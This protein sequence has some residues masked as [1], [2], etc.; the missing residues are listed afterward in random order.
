MSV[1]TSVK[2]VAAGL[3][4]NEPWEAFLLKAVKPYVDIVMQAGIAERFYF[5][6]S[7]ERGPHIRL[8]F[9]GKAHIIENMLKP[10]MEEHFSYFFE[11]RGS[12]RVNPVYPDNFPDHL[13][14]HPNNS[15]HYLPHSPE[16]RRYGGPVAYSV[17]EKNFEASSRIVLQSLYEKGLRWTYDDALSTA[18]K[19]HICFAFAIG[20]DVEESALFFGQLYENWARGVFDDRSEGAAHKGKP[21]TERIL[22]FDRIYDMQKAS[23]IAFNHSLWESLE[24]GLNIGEGPEEE[25][26]Q[27][28]IN[29]NIELGLVQEAGKLKPEAGDIEFGPEA[30]L[31]TEKPNLWKIFARLV[32]MTNNRL[33]ILN[34]DEGYLFY[35]LNKSLSAQYGKH[36]PE[37]GTITR[38]SK[39]AL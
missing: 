26:I 23:M 8:C 7:W 16:N 34:G 15:L 31:S 9:K 2:W 6:R 28:N 11:E 33:G 10:N 4:Y 14:W 30:G 38:S 22:S 27:T 5:E 21:P 35:S 19:L 3:Y 37:I 17:C 25:W 18:N 12:F 29:L 13:K 20:M 32:H 1:S 36:L 39:T 24:N